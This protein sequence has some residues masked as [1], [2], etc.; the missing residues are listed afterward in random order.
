M[1]ALPQ[2]LRRLATALAAFGL[3][4]CS[5]LRID[6][7]VYQGPLANHMDVQVEQ[8][9]ALAVG[10]HPLLVQ[11]RDTVEWSQA[12]A[13][14]KN[15]E[16]CIV[17][18][19]RSA[20]EEKCYHKEYHDTDFFCGSE[21]SQDYICTTERDGGN[22][23]DKT[24]PALCSWYV[25]EIATDVNANPTSDDEADSGEGDIA[26]T[27][28]EPAVVSSENEETDSPEESTVP[29]HD[30]G[31]DG[32]ELATGYSNYQASRVND[33]L[34]LYENLSPTTEYIAE[35]MVSDWNQ[36]EDVIPPYSAKWAGMTG[37][38]RILL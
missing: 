29:T 24:V 22:N 26:E 1:T 25:I 17:E 6:V 13:E 28:Q 15:F 7:D 16:Q 11:L 27:P 10:A 34:G 30:D 9:A 12:C 20:F 8:F 18:K 35:R 21:A 5:V 2:L 19:R 4:A 38:R 32:F 23:P 3:G 36:Y 33:I 31:E 37:A 14:D